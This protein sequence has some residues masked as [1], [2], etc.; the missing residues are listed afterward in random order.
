VK[1]HDGTK[2]NFYARLGERIRR[3]R[4]KAGL[5]YAQLASACGVSASAVAK[6][7]DGTSSVTSWHLDQLEHALG[8]NHYDLVRPDDGEVAA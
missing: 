7:E 6:W 2:V 4:I 8:C 1:Y 5:S 3:L